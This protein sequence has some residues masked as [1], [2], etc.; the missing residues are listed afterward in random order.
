VKHLD[1]ASRSVDAALR[2]ASFEELTAK[3][4]SVLDARRCRIVLQMEEGC[5]PPAP[6][7]PDIRECGIEGIG[8]PRHPMALEAAG[9]AA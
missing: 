8:L 9:P 2:F 6:G 3:N 4:V 5:G 7:S 1:V